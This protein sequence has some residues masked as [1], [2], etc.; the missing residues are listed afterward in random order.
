MG[1]A[2]HALGHPAEL[3]ALAVLTGRAVGV[4]ITFAVGGLFT[5]VLM[6]LATESPQ[7]DTAVETS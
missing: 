6:D 3:V 4:L 1:A 7:N 5:Y 2:G